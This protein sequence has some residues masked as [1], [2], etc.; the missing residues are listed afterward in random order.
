[1]QVFFFFYALKQED[2]GFPCLFLYFDVAAT[3]K[4]VSLWVETDFLFKGKQKSC[5][6][7]NPLPS[8]STVPRALLSGPDLVVKWSTN[9]PP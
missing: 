9:K 8:V 7:S 3:L 4:R 2:G 5:N 1:M 6:L